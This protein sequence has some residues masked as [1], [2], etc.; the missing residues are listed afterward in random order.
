MSL[1]QRMVRIGQNENIGEGERLFKLTAKNTLTSKL[2]ERLANSF[3]LWDS[4]VI[5]LL[6]KALSQNGFKV[7]LQRTNFVISGGKRV[8]RTRKWFEK[9]SLYF[10]ATVRKA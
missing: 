7:T 9:G 2:L 5:P 1:N 4:V 8:F 3:G 6:E 10:W